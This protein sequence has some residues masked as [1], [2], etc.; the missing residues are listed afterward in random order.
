[1]L[2]YPAT[3]RHDGKSTVVLF[4]DFPEGG[5]T[6]GPSAKEALGYTPDA[7]KTIIS[8]L[9]EKGFEVPLPSKPSKEFP[10]RLAFRR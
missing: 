2:L 1:M 5:H 3:I 8:M 10:A 4:P 7:L 9:M 6:N